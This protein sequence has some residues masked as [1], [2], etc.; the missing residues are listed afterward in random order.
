MDKWDWLRLE[1]NFKCDFMLNTASLSFHQVLYICFKDKLWDCLLN[2]KQNCAFS[3]F[4]YESCLDFLL[5]GNQNN[6]VP[7]KC[8]VISYSYRLCTLQKPTLISIC[9]LRYTYYWLLMTINVSFEKAKF[10]YIQ[11]ENPHVIIDFGSF[12]QR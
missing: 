4:I 11:S 8:K 2:G 3:E 9:M 12:F 7:K 1:M 6:W 5:L 10:T